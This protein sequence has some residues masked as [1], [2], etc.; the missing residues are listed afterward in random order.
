MATGEGAG[1]FVV[2]LFFIL[3]CIGL[4]VAVI[5]T[6]VVFQR[7]VQRHYALI[8]RGALADE[9]RV[10]DLSAPE[11]GA[12]LE[13]MESGHA[14]GERRSSKAA[15]ANANVMK[16]TTSAAEMESERERERERAA[17]ATAAASE[18]RIGELH[19]ELQS[20]PPGLF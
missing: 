19:E 15:A 13:M 4:I 1:G 9:W 5:M 8:Q 6:A 11:D 18:G 7:I 3:V 16:R 14:G 17:T 10:V 20:I 12:D 2:V